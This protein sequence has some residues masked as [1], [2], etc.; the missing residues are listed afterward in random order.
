[1]KVNPIT[2]FPQT[3]C[4]HAFRLMHEK[5]IYKLP[6]VAEEGDLTGI[7]TKKDLLYAL[8]SSAALLSL[9]EIDTLLGH[10]TVDR[11]MTRRVISVSE[12]CPLEEA[13][14]IMA[15]SQI[16]GLPVT[17]GDRLLGIITKNDIFR[18]MLEALGGRAH[19]LRI[20]IRLHA[21]TGELG[22][23][24]DGIVRLGGK[25]TSLSTFW[26]GDSF[27]QTVMLKVRG[28][29]PEELMSLL[30]KDIGV[31]VIDCRQSST[32]YQPHAVSSGLH[33]AAFPI[34][35]LHAEFTGLPLQDERP[36][37]HE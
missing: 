28:V 1:M 13:A 31:Q 37:F 14:R 35:N 20:M 29:D 6:V 26:G 17:R 16:G 24:T 21:D 27:R 10:M 2:V 33:S 18:A 22:A 25:L 11:V 9:F 30:E 5:A 7:V 8:P 4:S 15:D 12:D 36:G 23:I 34:Q 3:A 19:G 32:E